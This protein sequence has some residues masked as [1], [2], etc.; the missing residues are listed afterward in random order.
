MNLSL[1][2]FLC[3]IFALGNILTTANCGQKQLQLNSLEDEI[4]YLTPSKSINLDSRLSTYV[5]SN[6]RY[7]V[8]QSYVSISGEIED[9]IRAVITLNIA[10]YLVA[11]NW[12]LTMTSVCL[13]LSERHILKL[14]ITKESPMPLLWGKDP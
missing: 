13:N 14:E 5:D 10:T 1:I 11:E 3:L 12:P 7:G 4:N 2:R 9:Q 6:E 8:R